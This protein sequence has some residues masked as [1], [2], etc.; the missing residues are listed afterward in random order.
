MPKTKNVKKSAAAAAKSIR[1]VLKASG[2]VF[3]SVQAAKG[4]GNFILKTAKGKEVRCGRIS[5]GLRISVGQIVVTEG[6]H[7]LGVEVIGVIGDRAEAERMVRKGVLPAEVLMAAVAVGSFEEAASAEL[8]DLFERRPASEGV[9][10]GAGGEIMA[11][12]MKDQRAMAASDA[13]IAAR[14]AALLGGKEAKEAKPVAVEGDEDEEEEVD[15]G[16]L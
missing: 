16:D 14:V 2:D 10:L 1:A 12:S 5:R 15:L 11:R 8:D 3:M 13:A 4:N 6:E 7:S 9:A